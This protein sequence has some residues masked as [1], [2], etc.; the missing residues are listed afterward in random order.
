[1]PSLHILTL[2]TPQG[3]RLD[4]L[5]DFITLDCVLSEGNIGTLTL[6]L[7]PTHKY[8]F[9][10]RDARIAYYR[11]PPNDLSAGQFRLV[12]NTLW[13]LT[14]RA[15]QIVRDGSGW[16]ETIAIKAVHPNHL[17]AR[18]VVAYDEGTTNAD[19][20]AAADDMIKAYVRENFT[21][22]SDT[23]RNWAATLFAVDADLVAAPS[24][25]KAASYRTV[26]TVCQELAAA[27]ATAGTYTN[28]EIY[29]PTPENGALRLRT[30]T[31]Q[32]GENRSSSSGQPLV[33]SLAG[34]GFDSVR[35][36]E[37]WTDMASVVYAGGSGRLDERLVPTA[38]RDTDL[39]NGSPYGRIEWFQTASG[40]DVFVLTDEG[41]RAL[42]ERRP[43]QLFTA[44]VRDTEV[45]TFGEEFDWGDR[46]IGQYERPDSQTG[47]FTDIQQFDCR[48]DPVRI[49]VERSE[50][51][52]T[53]KQ[54]E[55]E[56]LDIRLRSET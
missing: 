4:Y 22:A 24:V 39:I 44:S 16:R 38:V 41:R 45:A 53:G 25:Q 2:C 7:P 9:F 11:A 48:V 42:R 23:T 14:G 3:D 15:R 20:T 46:V 47:V 32:R 30:Y 43:R 6:E 27:A 35:L 31:G 51:P 26:L 5:S 56:T 17:L 28:F 18:R 1:M 10:Q 54:R 12:G 52:E 55:T 40:D 19:K 34:G 37:D 36:E 29:C 49:H 8:D 33:L 13:L 50:D 21:A